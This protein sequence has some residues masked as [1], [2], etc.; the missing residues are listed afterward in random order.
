MLPQESTTS[1]DVNHIKDKAQLILDATRVQH[2]V[3]LAEKRLA[4]S[5]VK[6]NVALGIL[7]KFEVSEAERSLQ[8]ANVDISYVCHS[9]SK[10][11]IAL[12]EGCSKPRKCHRTSASQVDASSCS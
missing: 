4:D 2:N 10:S 12:Y 3:C 6:A 11:G 7:Y 5:I 9:F 1:S 8:E